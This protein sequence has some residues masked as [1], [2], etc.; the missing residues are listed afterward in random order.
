M[1]RLLSVLTGVILL[2]ATVSFQPV[3][4]DQ[5]KPSLDDYPS[6]TY[7]NDFLWGQNM[8]NNR[9]GYDSPDEYSEEAIYYAAK[10]GCKIM[11]YQGQ[12]PTDDFDETDRVIGL[13]NK[14]GMKVM[15]MLSMPS[16]DEPTQEDL[17]YITQYVK[18]F[19]DRYNGKNGRAKVDYFQL[20]NELEI[21][22]MAA[23]YGT[24]G[25][26]TGDGTNNYYNI[27]VEGARDLVEWTKLMKAA[28]KGLKEAD[29]DAKSVINFSWKA[30]GCV[31]YYYEN[32]VDFDMLGWDWYATTFDTKKHYD[33]TWG[34]MHGW[35][36]DT[37]GVPKGTNVTIS[38]NTVTIKDCPVRIKE[39]DD[40]V[41]YTGDT[42]QFFT[43]Q[44][45]TE[46]GDDVMV[47]ALPDLASHSYH[48]GIREVF[49]DKDLIVCE[50][51]SWVQGWTN[52]DEP[53]PTENYDPFWLTMEM[54]YKEPWIKGLCAFKLTQSPNHKLPH[55]INY[56]FLAVEKNSIPTGKII[57]PLP[58][59]YIYQ[60]M[61]GGNDNVSR[62][63][64]SSIDLK[65]YEIFKV[66]TAIGGDNAQSKD[67]NA[68]SNSISSFDFL[69]NNGESDEESESL[70]VSPA[71]VENIYKKA[72]VKVITHKTPWLLLFLLSGGI[73]L[74]FGGGFLTFLLL[75]KR[76]RRKIGL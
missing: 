75:N 54:L 13:C 34:T 37:V 46:S 26:T 39:K 36:S 16:Y 22:M 63:A 30:F 40:F 64:K 50:A 55:E 73:L 52:Y 10:M 69:F 25:A 76:K 53:M 6:L 61:I 74:L 71:D 1:K 14:Y 28:V 32:G 18:T 23:K 17:D 65:P 62:I 29:T 21:D 5:V 4:A 45:V 68:G 38:G 44:T 48:K 27:S 35:Y 24:K 33:N 67:Q 15:L 8:H 56:G 43:A 31:R 58:N 12:G 57:G 59:Y 41:V 51:N 60:K 3:S 11:R 2:F 72:T 42:P 19:G 47:T 66:R 7:R 9:R 20:W 49:P 70:D